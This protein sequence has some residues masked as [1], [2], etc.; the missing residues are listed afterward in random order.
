MT[1]ERDQ[2][3]SAKVEIRPAELADAEVIAAIYNEGIAGRQ[4]TFETEPR[5][6]ADF[7]GLIQSE[8]FPLLVAKKDRAVVGWAGISSYSTR[9]AYAGVTELSIYVAGH[10]QGRGVGRRLIDALATEAE[11]RGFHKIIGKL[12]PT[13]TASLRL[14]ERA[15]F[16][17]V[18]MHRKH[19]RL[20][21]SWRDVVV[22]ELLLGDALPRD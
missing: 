7:T 17:E 12:F 5:T 21:G 14:L 4:A 22:L 2:Q 9:Q 15:G 3:R 6:G 19:A 20:D 16:L 11:K 10:A 1:V 8:R 18:G 13:N